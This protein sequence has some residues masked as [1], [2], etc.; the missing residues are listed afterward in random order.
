MKNINI[1]LYRVQIHLLKNRKSGFQDPS[2]Y[3]PRAPQDR[4]RRHLDPQGPSR[5]SQGLSGT[6][7]GPSQD[8]S[9]GP[10]RASQDTPEGPGT[11]PGPPPN[12]QVPAQGPFRSSQG[13]SGTSLGPSQMPQ[14]APPRPPRTPETPLGPP[15][16]LKHPLQ[17][18]SEP[19]SSPQDLFQDRPGPPKQGQNLFMTPQ[20][21]SLQPP[22]LQRPRRDSRSDNNYYLLARLTYN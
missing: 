22:S 17:E 10:S 19:C 15:Q 21:T 6:S 11:L 12:P 13:L 20:A 18:L 7:L 1:S 14:D 16:D 5:S 3:A 8:A 9:G 4:P 2:K